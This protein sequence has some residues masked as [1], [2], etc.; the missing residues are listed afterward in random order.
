M[1][2]N[3]R[4]RKAVG[5]IGSAVVAMGVVA[6]CGTATNN[7]GGT[8]SSPS[9]TTQPSAA[10]SKQFVI[11]F[12]PGETTDPFFISMA[13]GAQ[14]EAKK[15]GV[16]LIYEGASTYSP[17]AQTPYVNAMVSR[18][19]NAL[20]VCPTDLTAMIPPIKQA[21]NAGIK[22]LTADSTISDVSLLTSRITSDNE[23]GGAAAADFLSSMAHGQG[24]VG[25]LDPSPGISTDKARVDGFVAEMKKKYPKIKVVIEY[26]NEQTT[27]AEQLAQD[28]ILHYGKNLVGIFGTD[29]TSASGAAQGVRSSGAATHV[30]IV[31]YDAEPAEVQ[32]LK[33]GMISA[34]IAQKPMIE[35]ELAVEYAVDA[36]EHKPVP[37]FVQL[38]NVVI[39]KSN[40]SHNQQWV[41][42]QS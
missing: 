42:R 38:P 18:H 19:V 12:V 7:S 16:K 15:L 14:Q 35:G 5:L 26:D 4:V 32:D 33:E 27:Q 22:V 3:K 11:G 36:L 10:S 17:S 25:V 1:K 31:G 40:L 20:I 37:K 21:V 28:L 23:Q 2:M 29:D 30:N 34:L 41:Y 13:Y 8:S 6:G 24:V 9:K 39:T